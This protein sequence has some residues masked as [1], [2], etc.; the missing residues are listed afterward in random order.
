MVIHTA[1]DEL[2]AAETTPEQAALPGAV[3]QAPLLA[4]VDAGLRIY[5]G[6]TI[7]ALLT[8]AGGRTNPRLAVGWARLVISAASRLD[9]ARAG[10]EGWA[11][12]PL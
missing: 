12:I 7:G 6:L 9:I 5:A 1:Q 11:G 8:I 4:I 3:E 2:T 10:L